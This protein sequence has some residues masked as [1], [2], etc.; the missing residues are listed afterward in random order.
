MFIYTLLCLFIRYYR[1]L[2]NKRVRIER[3]VLNLSSYT[4]KSGGVLNGARGMEA[5]NSWIC[6]VYAVYIQ[7]IIITNC[8]CGFGKLLFKATTAVNVVASETRLLVIWLGSWKFVLWLVVISLWTTKEESY[9]CL[10]YTIY[11]RVGQMM[12]RW[13]YVTRLWMDIITIICWSVMISIMNGNQVYIWKCVVARTRQREFDVNESIGK[14][15]DC[16]WIWMKLDVLFEVVIYCELST[17]NS[18]GIGVVY[19]IVVRM[20][21]CG[22][23]LAT[24][25]S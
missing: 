24:T 15:V 7:D 12:F 3:R 10:C 16:I 25:T 13:L 23:K 19:V 8:T 18:V 2:F 14:W 6:V 5:M 17:L 1:C 20:D 22:W 9:I 4:R 11:R 21:V